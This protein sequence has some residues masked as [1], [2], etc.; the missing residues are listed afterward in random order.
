MLNEIGVPMSDN[1]RVP[2]QKYETKSVH[3]ILGDRRD[4]KKYE[5][6]LANGWE[7][8][9]SQ[10]GKYT[11]GERYIFRRSVETAQETAQQ[12]LEKVQAENTKAKEQ[13]AKATEDFKQARAELK[14]TMAESKQAWA[15]GK[16]KLTSLFK[17]NGKKKEADE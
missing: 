7:V 11:R 8:E 13:N 12:K 17:R 15:E 9:A 6:L 4:R 5:R 2:G 14:Q 1:P 3:L 16:D 10:R